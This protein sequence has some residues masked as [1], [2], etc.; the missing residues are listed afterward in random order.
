MRMRPATLWLRLSRDA[1]FWLR[2]SGTLVAARHDD[3][4]AVLAGAAADER[5]PDARRRASCCASRRCATEAILGGAHIATDLQTDPRAAAAAIV[6]HLADARRRVP[7]PHRRDRGSRAG[8]VE[9]TRGPLTAAHV[10]VAVNHDLDQLLPELAERSGVVR[11]ALDMMRAAVSLPR[12]LAAP[13]LTGLV[14]RAV[15]PLRGQ[16][17]GG[18]AAR[19]AAR[20]A[21]RPRRAR[22]EPDVHAAAGRHAD[23][24][25]LARHGRARRRRSSPRPRSRAFLAEAEALFDMPAPRVLERWQ[26]V[27]AKGADEFLDR[28]RA[29]REYSCSPRPPASA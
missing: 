5:H 18:R 19:A 28:T 22:S 3:E 8:R 16:S 13:L 26:G 1:G 25:R 20:R 10:V 7:V 2:E 6:R 23:H 4:I 24:R 27:Y 15:R 11:C 17:A 12:P 21:P 14:A 9:T 29:T